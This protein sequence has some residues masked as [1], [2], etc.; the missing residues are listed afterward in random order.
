MFKNELVSDK[1][2]LDELAKSTKNYTGA[3]IAGVVK[4]AAS[5]SLNRANNL[6]DL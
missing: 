2:S 4:S 3:E 6:F 1:V 5:F